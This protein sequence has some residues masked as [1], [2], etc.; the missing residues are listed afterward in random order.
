[1][2]NRHRSK[3]RS[4]HILRSFFIDFL[5]HWTKRR[6][7]PR[8]CITRYT[9]SRPM[10]VPNW[11]EIWMNQWMQLFQILSFYFYFCKSCHVRISTIY[12]TSK[13]HQKWNHL[14]KCYRWCILEC[15]RWFWPREHL[16][17]VIMYTRVTYNSSK[18]QQYLIL[19]SRLA[20]T[21]I[22]MEF[23]IE[24]IPWLHV[25]KDQCLPSSLYF[26]GRYSWLQQFFSHSICLSHWETTIFSRRVL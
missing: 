13:R 19:G 1:M 22:A 24:I 10:K 2:P 21:I 14:R 8:L 20:Q 26:A 5:A 17:R 4:W 15:Y 9:S 12:L 16:F 7:G 18:R 6:R 11:W 25:E 3:L 23:R